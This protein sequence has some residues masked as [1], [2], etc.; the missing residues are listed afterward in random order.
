MIAYTKFLCFVIAFQIGAIVPLS[1]LWSIIISIITYGFLE[2]L[3]RWIFDRFPPD[4]YL[5]KTRHAEMYSFNSNL[6]IK[7]FDKLQTNQQN[8]AV[9][10]INPYDPALP[11]IDITE[12]YRKEAKDD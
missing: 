12:I 2:M 10:L 8:V 9:Y 3:R 4:V 1:P 5:I 7:A 6:L 11:L